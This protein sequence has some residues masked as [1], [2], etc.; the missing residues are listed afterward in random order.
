MQ[1]FFISC[2]TILTVLFGLTACGQKNE[3]NLSTDV[4]SY[5][6]IR[7][8]EK[9]KGDNPG[10]T[11]AGQARAEALVTKLAEK[12]ITHIYSSNYRRTMETATPLSNATGIEISI[13]DP[14]DLS[15][16]AEDIKYRPGNYVIVGHSNTTP[17]LASL[18]SGKPMDVMD[19]DEYDRFIELHLN[20]MGETEDWGIGTYGKTKP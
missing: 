10:L 2:L 8:A 7:H 12:N 14:S 17:V 19:E 5:Y 11:E 4:R 16:L 6:L 15:G 20:A 9:D 3:I 13:Y 1:R 18:I